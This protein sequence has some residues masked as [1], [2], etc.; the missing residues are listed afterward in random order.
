MSSRDHI[1]VG[2]GISCSYQHLGGRIVY[3]V[4]PLPEWFVRAIAGLLA[5]E[6]GFDRAGI[7]GWGVVQA[8]LAV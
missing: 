4:E 7:F 5:E 1:R 6:L 8:Q 2:Q 3:A